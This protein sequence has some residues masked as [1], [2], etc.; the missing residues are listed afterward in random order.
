MYCEPDERLTALMIPI[1]DLPASCV[2]LFKDQT[3]E[4]RA[5]VAART[6]VKELHD[7]SDA[8]LIAF[9]RDVA[10]VSGVL[11]RQF[12]AHKINYAVFGDLAP[13]LH[14]HLVPKKP[15]APEWGQ[16]FILKRPD[17]RLLD[18]KGYTVI[19]EKI[20]AALKT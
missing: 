4:G 9:T 20:R 7:F 14:F 2:Y 17:A 11:E 1:T 3:H 10:R 19:V 12:G 13:H 5:I 16:P 6:H 18:E 8:D 15:D